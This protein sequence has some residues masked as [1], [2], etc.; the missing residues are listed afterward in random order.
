MRVSTEKQEEHGASLQTQKERLHAYCTLK[1]L[2]DIKEYLD[3]GSGRTTDKRV[4]FKR[5]MDDVKNGYVTNVVILKLDRLTRS[6]IDLNKLIQELN[7]KDCQLHST[8]ENIDTTT[9]SGRMMMNLIGTFAQWESETISERVS[10]NMQ[11]NARKGL[12]QSVPPFGFNLVDQRLEVNWKEQSVLLEAFELVLSG[13]SFG[14]AERTISKKH[15]LEWY[16]GFLVKKLRAPSTVGDMY[17][18]G[19]L[20]KDLYP[21]LITKEYKNKLLSILGERGAPRQIKF[22]SDDL[23]RRKII[24]HKC[25]SVMGLR[26]NRSL[27]T[28]EYLYSYT[29]HHC[30]RN[31]RGSHS[32][33]EKVLE[34]AF[35]KRLRE[36][37]V[38]IKFNQSDLQSDDKQK[39]INK[40]KNE[41]KALERQKKRVQ[42][43][44]IQEMMEM[45]ELI[46][47][48][49]EIDE[50]VIEVEERLKTLNVTTSTITDDEILELQSTLQEHYELM[51]KDEKVLFIQQHIKEIHYK[52]TKLEG[53]KR[54]YN[55]VVT[56]IFF[57]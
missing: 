51:S 48:Q 43:A 21:P 40:L 36:G 42:K 19:E 39:E 25:S 13:S 2:T 54:K 7:E 46:E 14:N 8:T 22:K 45:D 18:N 34:D 23:F 6:I 24:C 41:L 38:N 35:I 29:C 57:Y 5:M 17:R 15:N 37:L 44:W 3:V 10:T 33:G 12:W 28:N 9:A 50:R 53:Y 47:H 32:V 56:D 4:N 49:N 1:G 55:T 16:D 26:A 11:T 30:A 27:R 31:G 52:R 20:V